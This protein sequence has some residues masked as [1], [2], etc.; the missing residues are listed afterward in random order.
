MRCSTYSPAAG[1]AQD[2]HDDEGSCKHTS[3][4]TMLT[5]EGQFGQRNVAVQAVVD[6]ANADALGLDL[7]PRQRSRVTAGARVAP[8]SGMACHAVSI[9]QEPSSRLIQLTCERGY[10]AETAVLALFSK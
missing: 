6:E 7:H 10:G 4:I 8:A 9:L 2:H 5:G 3:C 1:Q